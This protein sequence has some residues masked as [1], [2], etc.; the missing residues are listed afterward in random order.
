MRMGIAAMIVYMTFLWD[1]GDIKESLVYVSMLAMFAFVTDFWDG[2]IAKRW[3]SQRSAWGTK[4]D[5][6][7]D[8]AAVFSFMGYLIVAGVFGPWWWTCM[9]LLLLILLR[10]LAVSGLRVIVGHE[11]MQVVQ[12]GRVKAF[13][14]MLALLLFGLLPTLPT[15][16]TWLAMATLFLATTLTITSGWS[17]LRPYVVRG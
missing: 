13:F 14:Q 1:Q 3:V 6:V 2:W 5:P 17:Y 8:K 15:G 10:E 7:A 11:N 9:F 12:G 16:F 4:W